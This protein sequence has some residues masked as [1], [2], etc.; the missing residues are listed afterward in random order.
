MMR[1][2]TRSL[3]DGI[4][5]RILRLTEDL[6][7]INERISTGKNVNRPS[8]DPIGLVDALGLKTALSQVGQYQ[9]NGQKGEAWL[10]LGESVLSQTLDLVSR[11]Q[12]ITV[13]MAS[14][15]QDAT[16][17]SNAATEVGHLLDQAIALGNTEL[18]GS[19]IFAGYKTHTT[20][21]SKVTSGGVETAQ[22]DGD[23][24]NFEIPVGKDETLTIGK[25]GQA[26]FMDSGLFDVLG[27]L[28]KALEDNDGDT[29]RQQ[30][31]QLKGAENHL[32]NQIAD[33]G[34]KSNRLGTRQEILSSLNLQIEDQLS[35][36]QDADYAKL[37]VDLNE[38]QLVYQAA[39]MASV[40]V[41][42]LSLMDYLG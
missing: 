11:A 10:N 41:S 31:D 1:V 28:K 38:K 26:V 19:Y 32:N 34:A 23:T 39:L 5:E 9:R 15:T 27:N 33:M 36:V 25:N 40:K 2:G 42:Q 29:I 16:T 7:K 4:E 8:D 6:R 22:Y 24:N 13:Q 12:Q 3:Y 37:T 21:F 14:D 35:Q 17:R 18:G 20:P 30:I